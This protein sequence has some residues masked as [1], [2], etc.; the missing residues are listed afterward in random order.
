MTISPPI[1]PFPSLESP[2]DK[3]S[4][5]FWNEQAAPIFSSYFGKCFRLTQIG[6]SRPLRCSLF[7]TGRSFWTDLLPKIS[8][9]EPA[10]KHLLLATSSVV[11]AAALEGVPI[12]ESTVYQTHYAKAVAATCSSPDPEKVLTACLMFAGCEFMKGSIQTGLLHIRAGLRIMDEWI[13]SNQEKDLQLSSTAI[14]IA[15]SIGPM[16]L[17][18]VDKAPTYGLGE[19]PA[20]HFPRAMIVRGEAELPAFGEFHE[21]HR[22]LHALDGIGH[23]VARMMDFRTRAW[24]PSPHHKVQ[25]L[26]ESWRMQFEIFDANLMDS[27]RKRFAQALQMLRIGHTMLSIMLRASSSRREDV[28]ESFG[29]EFRWIVD[30]YDDFARSWARGE[31]SKLLQGE[32]NLLYY[33]MGL[34][35][36]LFFTATKCRDPTTRL[37]ALRHLGSLGVA[38][39]NWTSCSAYAIARTVIEIE[40]ARSIRNERCGFEAE[41]GLI[42]PVEAFISGKDSSQAILSYA[43]FPYDSSPLMQETIDLQVCPEATIARWVSPDQLLD[44]FR[45]NY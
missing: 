13:R 10:I 33:N 40:T 39:A 43:V 25:K 1:S 12:D 19:V 31:S 20:N 4:F 27:R 9:A 18:Y 26:L 45:N 44:V 6:L 24:I 30:R 16:L 23:H 36:P 7:D 42:R 38:E 35:P 8:I 2:S 21:I 41:K 37:A 22:A 29:E 11:E 5:Q 34:I 15:Q 32:G 3:R 14:L 17:A 28:Y